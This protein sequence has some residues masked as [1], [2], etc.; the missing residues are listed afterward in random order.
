MITMYFNLLAAERQAYGSS[1]EQSVT[2]DHFPN[3]T[4]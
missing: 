1:G 3:K 4:R 2:D